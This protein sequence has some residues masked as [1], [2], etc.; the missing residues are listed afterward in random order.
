MKQANNWHKF[1]EFIMGV[2]PEV[3]KLAKQDAANTK[4]RLKTKDQ[5]IKQ[6]IEIESEIGGQVFG[7]SRPDEERRF[8]C[9]DER[10]W[11]YQNNYVDL[12]DGNKKQMVIRYELHPNG[13]L[14]V[15]NSKSHSMV[16]DDEAER[17]IEAIKLYYKLVMTKVYGRSIDAIPTLKL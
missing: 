13:V 15:I 8:Y 11:V 3:F 12:I 16:Q 4:Q 5:K 9:L 1:L 14:K 6:L 17:L 7:P 10:T 2:D